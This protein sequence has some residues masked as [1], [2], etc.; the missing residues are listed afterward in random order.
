MGSA[1]CADNI[2]TGPIVSQFG[3][4]SA[5]AVPIKCAV[6]AQFVALLVLQAVL[7][8]VMYAYYKWEQTHKTKPVTYTAEKEDADTNRVSTINDSMIQ[9]DENLTYSGRNPGMMR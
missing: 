9:M 5:N 6:K 8:A 7:I 2:V 1:F 4:F 3:S